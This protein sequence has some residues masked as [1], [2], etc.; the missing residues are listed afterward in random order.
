MAQ[1]LK[2]VKNSN[3]TKADP[4]YIIPILYM[5]ITRQQIELETCS[6]PL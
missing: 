3:P 2:L 4:G 1:N 5:A 6:S